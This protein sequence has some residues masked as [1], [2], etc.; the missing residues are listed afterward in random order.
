MEFFLELVLLFTGI[1]VNLGGV[2]IPIV[3]SGVGLYK[4]DSNYIYKGGN[5][6]NYVIFNNELWRILS[7]DNDEIKLI[8]NNSLGDMPFDKG[9]NNRWDN[10]SLNRYFNDNYLSSISDNYKGIVNYVNLISLDEYLKVN[11]NKLC[12]GMNLYFVNEGICN[13]S[14]Y[15]NSIA[16]SNVNNVIWTSTFDDDA[17]GVYY[18]GNTYFPDINPSYSKIGVVPVVTLDNNIKL[19]GNGTLHKPFKIIL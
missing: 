2:Y 19:F 13:K 15:I 1:K 17:G 9:G 8:R 16:S 5:P 4:E 18:V 3:N 10:S 6:D 11:S 12:L 14:N 7:F